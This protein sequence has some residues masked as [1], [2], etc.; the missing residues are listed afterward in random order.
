MGTVELVLGLVEALPFFGFE[1]PG[2]LSGE[3]YNRSRCACRVIRIGLG[4]PTEAEDDSAPK[5]AAEKPPSTPKMSAREEEDMADAMLQNSPLADAERSDERLP[6][7]DGSDKLPEEGGEKL[8][9]E[10]GGE[11]L[12]EE[13]PTGKLV[14]PCTEKVLAFFLVWI[15]SPFFL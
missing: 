3:S 1:I 2:I 8:S 10:E 11:K 15:S 13:T 7:G 5:S 14:M 12:P 9:E 6:E 4:V